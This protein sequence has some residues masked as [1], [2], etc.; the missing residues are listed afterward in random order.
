MAGGQRHLDLHERHG[1]DDVAVADLGD[2]RHFHAAAVLGLGDL[3][4]RH[5][6]GRL[7]HLAGIAIAGKADQFGD[8]RRGRQLLA[9]VKGGKQRHAHQHARGDAGQERARQPARRNLAPIGRAAAA[10]RDKRRLIA[11]FGYDI[12]RIL[13][14]ERLLLPRAERLVALVVAMTFACHGR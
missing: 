3:A 9:P 12:F 1:V 14:P 10:V 8:L 11:E 2:H 5:Q 6:P 13:H 4:R 7:G